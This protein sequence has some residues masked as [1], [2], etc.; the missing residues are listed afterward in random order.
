MVSMPNLRYGQK[1]LRLLLGSA[2]TLVYHN[3][4]VMDPGLWIQLAEAKGMRVLTAGYVETFD[5][6]L[7]A[8]ANRILRIAARVSVFALKRMLRLLHLDQIPN[9]SFSPHILIVAKKRDAPGHSS[10]GGI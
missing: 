9:R 4:K 1:L 5:F 6:W 2:E 10:D 3:L 7:P 8:R